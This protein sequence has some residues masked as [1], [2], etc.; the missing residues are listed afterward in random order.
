MKTLIQGGTIVTA[1]DHYVGDVLVDGEII[2]K[3][4]TELDRGSRPDHRC[5]R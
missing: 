4:G 5:D 1:T 3:L 2:S